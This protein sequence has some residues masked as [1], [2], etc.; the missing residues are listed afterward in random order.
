MGGN[1]W[2]AYNWENNASNAGSD[3]NYQNDSL[4]G[5]T[6]VAGD[7]V[8]VQVAAAQAANAAALVPVPI[9]GWVAA[10]KLGTSVLGDPITRRFR[11][12]FG[13]I[14]RPSKM[15]NRTERTA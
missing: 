6:H 5:T 12:R 9:T 3:Y 4:L 13:K 8:R 15:G 11:Q 7:P 2:T 10:D 14:N 1:R